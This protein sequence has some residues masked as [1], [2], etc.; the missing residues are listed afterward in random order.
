MPLANYSDLQTSV[1][2]WIKRSDLTAV[3]P[4]FIRLAE[5]RI[6]RDLT[7]RQGEIEVPVVSVIGSRFIALPA[8]YALPVGLF[9]TTYQ[10]RQEVVQVM[11]SAL[12]VTT[13]ISQPQ[14]WAVD[15][16][17]IAF[18]CPADAVYSYQ[19]RYIKDYALSVSVPTNDI[20]TAHPDLYLFGTLVE[21]A[22]YIL[23]DQ[24]AAA[25]NMKYQAAL[26]SANSAESQAFKV[27]PLRTD[28]MVGKSRFDI[29]RGY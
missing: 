15:G 4:D 13:T 17:N 3:I 8:D 28:D 12:P 2:A 26:D 27:S 6:N 7:I 21:A 22:N 1:A 18:E 19:F 29:T 10:P 23:D 20:L 11:A 14:Y 25:W 5:S 16:T 24:R 9:Q